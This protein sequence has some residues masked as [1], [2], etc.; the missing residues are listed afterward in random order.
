MH[1]MNEFQRKL[2]E[3]PQAN[4]K[5]FAVNGMYTNARFIPKDSKMI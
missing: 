2:K 3:F 1:A 5:T 4:P